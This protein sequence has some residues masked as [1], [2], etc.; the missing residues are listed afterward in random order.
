[1]NGCMLADG[2][3]APESGTGASKG[4]GAGGGGNDGLPGPAG[5][6]GWKGLP[7]GGIPWGGP[8]GPPGAGTSSPFGPRIIYVLD[9]KAGAGLSRRAAS[10]RR[11]ISPETV[12]EEM[13]AAGFCFWDEPP[14]P[15]A[16]RFLLVF[17][18]KPRG[19]PSR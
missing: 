3:A 18:K 17:G 16:D 6:S 5:V 13:K 7:P 1:M 11:R 14:A 12:K 15:A 4:S 19:D 2:G 9:R 10:H 8:D